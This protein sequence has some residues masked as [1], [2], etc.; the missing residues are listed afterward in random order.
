[1]TD[2]AAGEPY[3]Y[4]RDPRVPNFP[5]ERPLIVFDGDCVMCSRDARFVL[6]HDP[7]GIFRLAAAQSPLG[8]ALYAHYGLDPVNYETNILIEDGRAFFKSEAVIR[9]GEALGARWRFVSALRAL[10]L[11]WRDRIYDEVARRR[12]RVFGKREVC[13]L[14]DPHYAERFLP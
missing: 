14:S 12:I 4:R 2:V 1:M 9:I 5:D 10:P 6:R 11:A 7:R 3:S 8:R 13:Y